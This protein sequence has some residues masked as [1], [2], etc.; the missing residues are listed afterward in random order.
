MKII[1]ASNGKKILKISK[2]EWMNIGEKVGWKKTES[3][4]IRMPSEDEID[5]EYESTYCVQD[6]PDHINDD[7][8]VVKRYYIGKG[9][10]LIEKHKDGYFGVVNGV[11]MRTVFWTKKWNEAFARAKEIE[12]HYSSMM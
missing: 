10:A 5:K 2:L 9:N 3:Q 8:S 1:T 7:N 11:H 4:L 6:P 12:A